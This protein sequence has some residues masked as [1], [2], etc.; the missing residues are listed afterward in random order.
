MKESDN[1]PIIVDSK[2]S[3]SKPVIDLEDSA[4]KPVV[5]SKESARKPAIVELK[6]SDDKP[7]ILDSK[8]DVEEAPATHYCVVGSQIIDV[9]VLDEISMKTLRKFSSQQWRLLIKKAYRFVVWLL[10]CSGSGSN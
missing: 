2:E 1:K 9:E 7:V 3:D 5:D 4:S 10:L 6:E 8:E